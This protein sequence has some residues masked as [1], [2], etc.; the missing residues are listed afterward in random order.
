VAENAR[1]IAFLDADYELQKAQLEL[2]N[3]TGELSSLFEQKP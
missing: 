2:L 1:W 3:M